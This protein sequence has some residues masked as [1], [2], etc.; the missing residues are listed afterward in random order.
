MIHKHDVIGVSKCKHCDEEDEEELSHVFAHFVDHSNVEV[1][2]FV[3][4]EEVQESQPHGKGSD[5]IESSDD[6]VVSVDDVHDLG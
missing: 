5:S 6:S 1:G 3:N 2:S 4:S